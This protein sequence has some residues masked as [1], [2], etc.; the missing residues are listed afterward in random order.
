MDETDHGSDINI[1][2]E[3]ESCRSHLLKSCRSHLL[4]TL[5]RLSSF[6]L[7]SNQSGPEIIEFLKSLNSIFQDLFDQTK[8][9][10]K[11]IPKGLIKDVVQG[12][13]WC[14]ELSFSVLD[15]LHDA[16][17]DEEKD[18]DKLTVKLVGWKK[19]LIDQLELV[20][21]FLLLE[22]FDLSPSD[23]KEMEKK[24]KRWSDRKKQDGLDCSCVSFLYW[25]LLAVIGK[26][27]VS[28]LSLELE[29]NG[30]KKTNLMEIDHQYIALFMVDSFHC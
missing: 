10:N 20:L 17:Q 27:I 2:K 25:D 24:E 26:W 29:S 8:R 19:E 16:N 15:V 22:S 11:Q 9:N 6:R 7:E 23:G 28:F 21:G 14:F 18:A 5:S 30:Q 4:N 13:E 12:W 3:K 1:M